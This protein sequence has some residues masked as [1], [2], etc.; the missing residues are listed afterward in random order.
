MKLY[1]FSLFFSFQTHTA[2][3]AHSY[4]LLFFFFLFVGQI[5]TAD[6]GAAFTAFF[7]NDSSTY[8][9]K[10]REL[11]NFAFFLFFSIL[12]VRVACTHYL[13]LTNIFRENIMLMVSQKSVA[14]RILLD[15]NKFMFISFDFVALVAKS[16]TEKNESQKTFTHKFSKEKLTLKKSKK[17]VVFSSISLFLFGIKTIRYCS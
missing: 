12:F 7:I 6:R 15:S 5:T 13:K 9:K 11:V 16:E 14:I 8:R 10:T 4:F 1:T 2:P 17:K 3:F